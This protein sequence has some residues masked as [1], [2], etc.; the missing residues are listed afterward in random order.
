VN[1][2]GQPDIWFTAMEEQTFPLYFGA[3]G[4]FSNVTRSSGLASETMQMSGWSNGIADFD[5]DGWKDL[6]VAR[7]NVLDNIADVS[8][9]SYREPNGVFR[10]MGNGRFENVSKSAG[11]DMQVA[12]AHRGSA[13]ADLDND[14]K[15]DV[16]VSVL[17]G[18]LKIFHNI[19]KNEN[20]WL[21]LQLVGSKS[22]R[23]GIGAKVHLVLDS[24]L[25]EYNQVTTSA[26]YASSSDSRV[27]F[28]LG[29]SRLARSIEIAWPSGAKQVLR[30]VAA[31]RI[32]QVHEPN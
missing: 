18:P 20:H 26:G 28:G 8:D 9:R 22:N 32:L 17:N 14:G 21:I 25:E 4:Q 2:D 29:K 27:H 7:S 15:I 10:N 11:P 3:N 5:N 19:T 12:G 23:M 30:D 24:G 16:V 31:D 6:F 1:N 13:V